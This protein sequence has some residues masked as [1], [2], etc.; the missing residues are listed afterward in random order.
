MKDKFAFKIKG[1]KSV[2]KEYLFP[3]LGLLSQRTAKTPPMSVYI[4]WNHYG[5]RWITVQI[6]YPSQI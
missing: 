1:E 6:P 4:K 2:G 3:N 5:M